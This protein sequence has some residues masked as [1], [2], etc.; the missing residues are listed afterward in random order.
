MEV[1]TVVVKSGIERDFVMTETG[2]YKVIFSGE[3]IPGQNLDQVKGKIASI[4]KIEEPFVQKLFSGKKVTIVGKISLERAEKYKSAF[5]RSG[6]LCRIVP[7]ETPSSENIESARMICPKC[8]F[9]QERREECLGCGIIVEKF[10][11]NT[12]TFSEKKNASHR[13]LPQAAIDEKQDS[14]PGDEKSMKPVSKQRQILCMVMEKAFFPFFQRLPEPFAEKAFDFFASLKPYWLNVKRESVHYLEKLAS[15]LMEALLFITISIIVNCGLLL[16]IKAGW[17]LYLSTPVGK[18]FSELFFDAT[19]QISGIANMDLLF[20]I[21]TTLLTFGI[22][23]AAAGVCRVTHCAGILY[24]YRNS[25]GKVLF[26]GL[27]ITGLVGWYFL[28]RYHLDPSIAFSAAFIPTFCLF[29]AC[30]Q[31]S[32]SLLPE[33]GS[34]KEAISFHLLPGL[35]DKL[36]RIVD[37]INSA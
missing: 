1:T 21:E 19:R 4:L 13:P 34:M 12:I 30:F 3:I 11:K 25:M 14:A 28:D 9:E 29:P 16:S 33:L 23:L 10:L 36:K 24:E 8:H 35:K 20:P 37:R 18:Q 2:S 31:I 26:C 7:M 17:A 15:A 5:H 27:P 32:I 6:A 22:C